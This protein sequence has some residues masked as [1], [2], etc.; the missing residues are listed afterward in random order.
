MILWHLD[1]MFRQVGLSVKM[2]SYL[3]LKWSLWLLLLLRW[4]LEM[5]CQRV[6]IDVPRVSCCARDLRFRM[7]LLSS[8]STAG[9]W[10]SL[11]RKKT[12]ITFCTI[13][14]IFSHSQ[15]CLWSDQKRESPVISS[16]LRISKALK[17]RRISIHAGETQ[18]GVQPVQCGLSPWFSYKAHALRWVQK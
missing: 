1:V 6:L 16:D 7:F 2:S 11:L 18:L 13:F 12:R 15:Q 3:L 8:S 5:T 14:T 9:L 17:V 4:L 10:L